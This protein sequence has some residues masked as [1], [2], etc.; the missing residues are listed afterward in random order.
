MNGEFPGPAPGGDFGPAGP[1]GGFPGGPA[2]PAPAPPE[3]EP[4]GIDKVLVEQ[5]GY[6][7]VG[8]VAYAPGTA[9][10]PAPA[11]TPFPGGE[12]GPAPG[13]DFGPAPGG[14]FPGGPAAPGGEFGPAPGGDFPGGSAPAVNSDQLQVVTL[15]QL[16]VVN[17]Q[18]VSLDQLQVVTLDQLRVVTS[19]VGQLHQVVTL[20]QL[21]GP[22]RTVWPAPGGGFPGGP[23]APAPAPEPEPTGIDKVLVEQFGY[24][25]VGRWL[26][27]QAQRL[28]QPQHRHHSQVV[29]SDQLRV[30]TLGQ[31]RVVSSRPAAP[32]GEF[33][34][35]PRWRLWAST[36]R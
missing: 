18:V 20:D 15:D 23:A 6:E 9:P 16:R 34:P 19:Q 21:R 17:S 31:H 12:F 22:G 32:G 13:G 33:G 4:T 24:E 35:A 25:F 11:P 5:F 10:E 28:N 7:F 1:G 36:G 2:A 27:H 14:G 8:G 30:A 3:P 26:M 29:S